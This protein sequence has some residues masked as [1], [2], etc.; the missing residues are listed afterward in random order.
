MRNGMM[1]GLMTGALLGGAAATIFGIVNWKTERRWHMQ[2]RKAGHWMANKT[3][4][5][6]G[7]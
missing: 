3:D 7:K 4:E 5:I 6:L 1:K 2:A